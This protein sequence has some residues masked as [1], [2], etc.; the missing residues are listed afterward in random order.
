MAPVPGTRGRLVS[1]HEDRTQ[2]QEIVA[3]RAVIADADRLQSYVEGFTQLLTEDVA[4]VNFGGRRVLGRGNV[5]EAMRQALETPFAH[6]YTENEVVD[7]RFLRPDVAVVSSVK[8]ISDKREP[9][10]SDSEAPMS[11]RGSAT[12]VLV[13]ERNSWLIALVQTTP[14]AI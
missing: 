12:F 6:V 13:R 5:H 1:R 14:I 3:I 2:D 7:V 10:A 4:L 9:P 8:H 11:E